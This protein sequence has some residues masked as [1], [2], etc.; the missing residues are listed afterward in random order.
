MILN[1]QGVHKENL[2]GPPRKHV[3]IY[4]LEKGWTTTDALTFY[5]HYERKGWQTI[6][7]WK[8][9]VFR[10]TAKWPLIDRIAG[11]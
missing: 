6:R 4:F 3:E 9:A 7:D 2:L 1:N 5:E 10:W 8:A 11:I